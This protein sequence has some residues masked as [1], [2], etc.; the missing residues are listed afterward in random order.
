[1]VDPDSP[2][3]LSRGD[4]IFEIPDSDEFIAISSDAEMDAEF[5]YSDSETTAAN[6]FATS[7]SL[8]GYYGAFS[9]AASMEVSQTSNK[10]IKTVR[11]DSVIKAIKYSVASKHQFRTFPQ[12]F[13]TDNF[14]AAVMALPCED[15]ERLIGSFYA[16]NLKLGGEVRKSYTMQA[17]ETDDVSSITSELQA[18]Y[19][20]DLMGV[21]AELSVG[22]TTRESNS[23]AEMSLAWSAKGGDP[24]VWLGHDFSGSDSTSVSEIQAEWDDTIT[25][26]NLY[27]FDFQ[28]GLMWDLVKAVNPAKGA[29]YQQYLESKWDIQ[30]GSFN[31]TTFLGKKNVCV[32]G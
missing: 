11:M 1:M 27:P 3:H 30:A 21:T 14:K 25:D 16:T 5:E 31:P 6:S 26:Q 18:S 15:I 28:L 29:E 10:N 19:G 13:L 17:M 12:N 23:N 7:V 8:E 24:T 32:G 20:T 9:A 4:V 22:I 2:D